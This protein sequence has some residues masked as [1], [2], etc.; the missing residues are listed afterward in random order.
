MLKITWCAQQPGWNIHGMWPSTF[1]KSNNPC[2][3]N[4]PT[5]VGSNLLPIMPQLKKYWSN[6]FS[7]SKFFY[8]H[9]WCKHGKCFSTN[10]ANR[11]IGYFNTTLTLRNSFDAYKIFQQSHVIPSKETT[12]TRKT[13]TNVL[14]KF[15]NGKTPNYK[16]TQYKNMTLLQEVHVCINKQLTNYIDCYN[17]SIATNCNDEIYYLPKLN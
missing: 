7:K 9:E 13:I 11:E 2:Y 15:T 10:N 1:N 5:F 12:Y 16:C 6:L 14:Q 4:G 8:I 3:C 17:T